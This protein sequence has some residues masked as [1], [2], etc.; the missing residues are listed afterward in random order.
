MGYGCELGD[1]RELDDWCELGHRYKLGCKCRLDNSV[2]M[3]VVPKGI[4]PKPICYK[5]YNNYYNTIMF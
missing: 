5:C 3:V 2:L 4:R 1:K